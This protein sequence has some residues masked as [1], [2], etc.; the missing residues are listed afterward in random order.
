MGVKTIRTDDLDGET[1]ADYFDV[2]FED[3]DGNVFEIDL[4]DENAKALAAAQQVFDEEVAA[5]RAK[6]AEDITDFLGAARRVVPVVKA[7]RGRS[8]KQVPAKKAAAKKPAAGQESNDAVRVWARLNGWP[9]VKD[10]GRIRSDIVDAYNA[11]QASVP[12]PALS[13]IHI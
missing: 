2:R 13:L 10:R 1:V 12:V 6:Y 7:T 8:V 3:L 5:A 9:D 4:C 11:A